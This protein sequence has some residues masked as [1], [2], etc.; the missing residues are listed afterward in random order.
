MNKAP[1]R[2]AD[3]ARQPELSIPVHRGVFVPSNI[4]S[5]NSGIGVHWSA[6][7]KIAEEMASHS[8]AE[9]TSW[10]SGSHVVHHG[11]VPISSIETNIKTLTNNAVLSPENLNKNREKEVPVK[12]GSPVLV[13]GRTK[14]T[15]RNGAWKM[16]ERTYKKP[17]EM[18]A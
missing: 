9:H 6:S 18:K 17:R 15:F 5:S 10:G 11:S 4:H 8:E 13:T 14:G 12:K 16:R 2:A 3:L 1:N 7:R